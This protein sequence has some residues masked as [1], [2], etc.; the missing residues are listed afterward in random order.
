M[1]I[2]NKIRLSFFIVTLLLITISLTFLYELSKNILLQSI[3]NNLASVTAT[4]TNQI[5]LYLKML[6]SSTSQLSKSTILETFLK[7]KDQE[8]PEQQETLS[9]TL[10]RLKRTKEANPSIYEFSLMDTSGKIVA[11]SNKNNIGKDKSTDAMFLGAQQ[12]IYIKDVFYSDELKDTAMTVSVPFLDSNTGA[13]LGV[14]ASVVKLNELFDIVTENTGM[15]STG[16]TY[17]VNKYQ[18]MITPSRFRKDS[19]LK[20]K[21]NTENSRNALLH[22]DK[23]HILTEMKA[24][25]FLDY[26][27][28]KVLGMHEFIPEMKWGVL[29]EIGINEVF[30]PLY[31][32]RLSFFLI[33]ISTPFLAWVFGTFISNSIAKPI[34]ILHKSIEIISSGN[35]NH[36]VNIT[37]TD[38]VGQL[39]KAFNKM[40]GDL[41]NTT[42]SVQNLNKEIAERKHAEE[43]LRRSEEKHKLLYTT[44]KDAMMTTS[45]PDWHFTSGN[46][47]AIA[48]FCAKDE[49]EFISKKPWELSPELQPDGRLSRDKAKSMIETAIREGSISFEWT[50]K[51]LN[52][53]EFQ[54]IVLLSK[55][56][57]ENQTAIQA[58]VRDITVQKRLFDEISTMKQQIE[59][60]LGATKTGL[61]IIDSHFNMIYIDPHWQTIYGDFKG[62]K[63]HEYFMGKKTVCENC[64][65]LKALKTKNIVVSEEVLPKENNRPVQVTT[66]PFQNKKGEWMVAE[67]NVDISERKKAEN[68][69]REAHTKLQEIQEQLIHTEKLEAIRR[70]ASG[71]AHEVRNPLAVILQSV[72]SLE[73]DNLSDQ[74]E[75]LKRIKEN[76]KKANNIISVLSDFSKSNKLN[77]KAEDI[78]L[79]LENSITLIQYKIQNQNIKLNKSLEQTLP[80]IILDKMR[81]EQVFVNIFLNSIDAMPDGGELYIRTYKKQSEQSTAS[82]TIS[83]KSSNN[84]QPTQVVIEIEDTGH[85][86][87][88]DDLKKVFEPFFTT[89]GP[90]KGTGMG[91]SVTK[92]I[93]DSHQATIEIKSKFGKGTTII[94]TLK[95]AE[96]DKHE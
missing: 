55:F 16:E 76:I 82:L 80:K 50:H 9:Q 12:H 68:D 25:T 15:G 69:L 10:K 27:G 79:V 56:E 70:L 28:I 93:L 51:R 41:R 81:M 34:K 49:A 77:L 85:G 4:R 94:I 13:F 43:N 35:L 36:I 92:A 29:S 75:T 33:F 24:N 73:L 54:T 46:P 89:K 39:A 32:L 11:S 14:L 23:T 88:E 58:T 66:I 63:C 74:K 48:M 52:G 86:I 38:E 6:K 2:A 95:T 65:I 19:V 40:T 3:E 1:K 61:D 8:T 5:E 30:K 62:K 83:N 18:Y 47:S 78:N 20:Q 59:F 67:V 53:E 72:G 42:T 31:I 22:A 44:S 91:L 96:A 57:L 87:K 26:R 45:P 17:I 71:V 90:D 37:T 21:V 7:T 60:I 84:S 64:G